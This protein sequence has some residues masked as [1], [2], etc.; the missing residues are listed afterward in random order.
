MTIFLVPI[1]ALTRHMAFANNSRVVSLDVGKLITRDVL[2]NRLPERFT[3]NSKKFF[4]KLTRVLRRLRVEKNSQALQRIS[5]TR[6]E[7][8]KNTKA[9]LRIKFAR[10]SRRLNDEK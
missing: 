7:S 5:V 9:K 4:P 6:I 8:E 1:R 10:S 3:P 2:E